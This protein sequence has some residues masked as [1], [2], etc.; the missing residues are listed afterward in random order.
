[1]NQ[2]TI[3][4]LLFCLILNVGTNI[5]R[6]VDKNSLK[7]YAFELITIILKMLQVDNGTIIVELF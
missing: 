1:M 2:V 4:E 7:E 5:D 3:E 6:K